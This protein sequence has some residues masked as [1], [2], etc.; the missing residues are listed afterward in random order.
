MDKRLISR[1][2]ARHDAVNVAYTVEKCRVV[3]PGERFVIWVQGCPLRCPGCENQQFLP[4][5]DSAWLG[6]EELARRIIA[7]EGIEGVT[8]AGGE[9]FAQASA[10]AAMSHGLRET[11]LTVMAYSGFT[12]S[13]LESDV[14]PGATELLGEIDLLLDGPFCEDEPTAKPWRGSDNQRLIALSSRYQGFV[15][16]WNA[17]LGQDFEIRFLGQG[18]VEFLGFPP[19]S[20][21]DGVPVEEG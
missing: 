19:R 3:G 17:P 14:V 16:L 7:V 2:S 13:Q 8:Y 4:F 11:G 1:I 6:V 15:S 18:Q 10:L 20:S 5:R 21:G 12:L 9:P